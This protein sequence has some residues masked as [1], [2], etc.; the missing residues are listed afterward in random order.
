MCIVCAR[1][2]EEEEEEEVVMQLVDLARTM[3]GKR[4]RDRDEK[5]LGWVV[6]RYYSHV[7]RSNDAKGNVAQTLVLIRK[8][9]RGGRKIK[10][11]RKRR[12]TKKEWK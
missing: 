10:N 8:E 9:K 4:E 7:T 5:S 11:G 6:G 2:E 1:V 12:R 3:H